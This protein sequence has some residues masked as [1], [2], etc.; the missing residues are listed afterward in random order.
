MPLAYR[1]DDFAAAEPDV[2]A[3]NDL[4]KKY[5]FTSLLKELPSRS[6]LSTE[7]YRTVLTEIELA[8][9][10]TELAAADHFAIDLETTSL[11]P[12]AAAIVGIA[13]S[14]REHEAC[15]IPVGHRYLGAPD[16]LPL[17]QVLATLKPLLIDAA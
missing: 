12:R 8:A 4:Y 17:E 13:L 1:L 16:Q 3:L 7:N 11:D 5:G 2:G 6:T 14:W 10:V 9:V 15:Y